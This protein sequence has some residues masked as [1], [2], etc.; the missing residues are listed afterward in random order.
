VQQALKSV[1]IIIIKVLMQQIL[2]LAFKVKYR[3]LPVTTLFLISP[4][5]FVRE[6]AG[7]RVKKNILKNNASTCLLIKL[8]T[9]RGS[10]KSKKH[11]NV[12]PTKVGIHFVLSNLDSRFHGNDTSNF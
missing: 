6:G 10:L 4:L 11:L 7:G 3:R 1:V 5:L 9:L 12:I 2:H 8:S